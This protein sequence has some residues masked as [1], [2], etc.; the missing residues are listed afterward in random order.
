MRV[1]ITNRAENLLISIDWYGPRTGLWQSEFTVDT[2]NKILAGFMAEAIEQQFAER[3]AQ[4]RR[5]AYNN[6]FADA[7]AK[8]ARSTWFS[9]KFCE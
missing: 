8:R 9:G 4:I 5:A 1:A 7:K 3:V 6:G 2:G